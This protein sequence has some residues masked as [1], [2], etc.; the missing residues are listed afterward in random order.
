L[1]HTHVKFATAA[2]IVIL[3]VTLLPILAISQPNEAIEPGF[4][5]T[6]GSVRQAESAGAT[7]NEIAALVALLN[8]ALELNGDALKLNATA[9]A[10]KRAQLISQVD[11]ILTTVQS[12][13]Q[14]LTTLA[15]QRSRMNKILTYI[16]GIL[17]AF[18]GTILFAFIVSF[19]RAYRIKRTFQMRI[20]RK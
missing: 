4:A 15:S 2:A 12:Q 1:P 10:N 19:Y 9:D 8:K 16:G 20:T 5:G 14:H 17:A 18:I 7:P 11:Q 6:L 13:A 3:V